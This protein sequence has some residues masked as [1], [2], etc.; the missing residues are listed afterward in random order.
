VEGI[1]DSG[2]SSTESF[3]FKADRDDLMFLIINSGKGR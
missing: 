3:N 2:P 1:A